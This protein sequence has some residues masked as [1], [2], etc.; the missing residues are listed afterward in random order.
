[1][2]YDYYRRV[3]CPFCGSGEIRAVN[4]SLARCTEC[5]ETMSHH[6]F[7][8]F[9]EIRSLTEAEGEHACECGHCELRDLTSSVHSRCPSCGGE[10][11]SQV[12][13][14]AR[15]AEGGDRPLPGPEGASS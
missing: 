11:T 13:R 12:K 8:T 15:R 5:G 14:R 2:T 7:D 1:M 3:L 6:F 4:P 10:I 9:L